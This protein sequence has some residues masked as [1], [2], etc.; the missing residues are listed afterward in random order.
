MC[1]MCKHTQ[2]HI[3][4]YTLQ[5]T[6]WLPNV[7]FQFSFAWLHGC[8]LEVRKERDIG[9]WPPAAVESLE[10]REENREVLALGAVES[11]VVLWR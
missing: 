3:C 2:T 5:E 1:C 11:W 10:V 4:L 8:V 6:K 9:L 7:N